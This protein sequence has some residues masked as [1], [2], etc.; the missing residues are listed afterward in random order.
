MAVRYRAGRA[1]PVGPAF[2]RGKVQAIQTALRA[3]RDHAKKMYKTS[4]PNASEFEGYT[5]TKFSYLIDALNQEDYE[6]VRLAILGD[7]TKLA[8]AINQA[9][10][11]RAY[12]LQRKMPVQWDKDWQEMIKLLEQLRIAAAAIGINT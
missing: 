4:D 11:F 6:P 5:I 3:I 2:D 9:K 7:S 1:V 10:A 8:Q 12:A